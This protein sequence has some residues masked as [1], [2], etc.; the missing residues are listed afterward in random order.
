MPRS[1]AALLAAVATAMP[2][3]A[4]LAHGTL[5]LAMVADAAAAAGL[6]AYLA[7]PALTKNPLDIPQETEKDGAVPRYA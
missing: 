6:G 1:M 5:F 3:L 2:A 4:A 7:A